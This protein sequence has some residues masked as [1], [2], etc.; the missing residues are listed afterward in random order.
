MDSLEK[1]ATALA[2]FLTAGTG[3]AIKIVRKIGTTVAVLKTRL[4][5]IERRIIDLE[6][7]TRSPEPSIDGE[8]IREVRRDVVKLERDISELG[9]K[10]TEVWRHLVPREELTT[11]LDK[12]IDHVGN[13]KGKLEALSG[14]V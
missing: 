11:K 4:D 12:L 2:A 9:E 13:V 3:G 8:I 7:R 6:S 10:L 1:V 14:R 5:D